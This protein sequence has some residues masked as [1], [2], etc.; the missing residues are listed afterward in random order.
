[1]NREDC[2]VDV[3]D[4]VTG[5][6]GREE[7]MEALD[8]LREYGESPV[9]YGLMAPVIDGL[10]CFAAAR[11]SSSTLVEPFHFGRPFSVGSVAGPLE[12]IWAAVSGVILCD[13][14]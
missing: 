9:A 12:S 10:R 3:T 8:A 2:V 4:D 1:M 11:S 13:C 7:P 6:H 5:D 14:L